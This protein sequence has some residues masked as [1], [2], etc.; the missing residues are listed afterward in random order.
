MA[1]S[2]G[3]FC[4]PKGFWKLRS[5][6][7]KR[8]GRSKTHRPTSGYGAKSILQNAQNPGARLDIL[9]YIITSLLQLLRDSNLK[10]FNRE[11]LRILPDRDHRQEALILQTRSDHREVAGAAIDDQQQIFGGI[12][13]NL[14]GQLADRN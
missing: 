10:Q 6:V 8:P 12:E 2:R 3:T 1:G 9:R 7:S 13:A 4:P 11:L 14:V 5:A